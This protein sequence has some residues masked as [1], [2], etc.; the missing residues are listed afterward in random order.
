MFYF[1]FFADQRH[2]AKVC[3]SAIPQVIFVGPHG[4]WSCNETLH[5]TVFNVRLPSG[6]TKKKKQICN[7]SFFFSCCSVWFFAP[8]IYDHVMMVHLICRAIA[9]H[10]PF[11]TGLRCVS[12]RS[13][14]KKKSKM[15][16]NQKSNQ[17]K[18]RKSQSKKSKI[19]KNQIWLIGSF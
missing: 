19:K 4:D 13:R 17:I 16:K 9:L 8:R 2:F 7:G 18:S 5:D 11:S 12:F 3:F 15:K 6:S 14:V 10:T 1:S